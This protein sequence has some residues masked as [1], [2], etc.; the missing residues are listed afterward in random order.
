MSGSF[1]AAVQTFGASE[2]PS[3]FEDAKLEECNPVGSGGQESSQKT[4]LSIVWQVA[5]AFGWTAAWL[6]AW[7]IRAWTY[8]PTD[9]E[10]QVKFGKP[11]RAVL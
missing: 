5:A 7:V 8:K 11:E 4:S 3:P 9:E 6:R 2:S 10:A 1:P